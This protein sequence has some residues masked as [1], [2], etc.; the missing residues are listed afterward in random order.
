MVSNFS[1]LC[2]RVFAFYKQYHSQMKTVSKQQYRCLQNID[3]IS[4]HFIQYDRS[5]ACMWEDLGPIEEIKFWSP[6]HWPFVKVFWSP[7]Q[8]LYKGPVMRTFD[9]L[10]VVNLSK[11]WSK[12]SRRAH[13]LGHGNRI[14]VAP[15]FHD[16]L[17]DCCGILI[18]CRMENPVTVS[19][20]NINHSY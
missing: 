6:R 20:K 13:F 7:V 15:L 12:R 9:V 4:A 11:L 10:F 8:C 3:V 17:S 18:Q 16:I 5:S 14:I 2:A 19:E 1:P